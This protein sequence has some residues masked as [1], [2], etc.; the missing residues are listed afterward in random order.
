MSNIKKIELKNLSIKQLTM[1]PPEPTNQF[2]CVS[3]DKTYKYKSGLDKH[4]AAKHQAATEQQASPKP[5]IQTINPV[6]TPFIKWVG[7]KSQILDAIISR[8]P[9]HINNYYEPFLGG[10]SVLFG[11]LNA[12]SANKIKLDGNIYASDLNAGLIATYINIKLTPETVIMEAEKLVD[13]YN[14][15]LVMTIPSKS[16]SPQTLD[17]AILSKENYYYWIRKLFNEMTQT[18]KQSAKGSAYFIFLNKTCFRGLYR[19]GPKGFNVPFGNYVNPGIIDKSQIIQIS[20][21]IQNIN[22]TVCP[23]QTAIQQ[24]KTGDFVYLDPPYAPKNETSFV[25]YTNSGFTQENHIELF[26]MCNDIARP[27]TG[28]KIIM[29]NADVK[30]VRDAFPTPGFN[31]TVINCKRHIN[32]KNPGATTNEVI[33]Q[34][35]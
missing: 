29:S 16:T 28:I 34:N 22:F 18:E 15:C 25:D 30:L 26:K 32:S 3:C 31:T 8:F 1:E 23:Y 13:A 14:T 9:K 24:A 4:N 19:E 6:I 20:A 33:I 11:L 21:A 12:I 27:Q 5:H 7:G 10:G 35:Y 17:E 2:T